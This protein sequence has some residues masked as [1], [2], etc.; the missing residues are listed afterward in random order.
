MDGPMEGIWQTQREAAAHFT[1]VWR[2]LLE[3]SAGATRGSP[4]S[5]VFQDQMDAVT[6]SATQYAA[7]ALKPLRELVEG[8]REFADQ[9]TRWAELQRDLA[10]NMATWAA[11][12]RDYVD[13]LDRLLA[14]F[15][16]PS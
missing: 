2:E 1:Q 15:T 12:Q 6:R 7:V 14:P 11:Q 8:Q 9:M 13:T 5:Q 10:D 4:A 3:S 16:P